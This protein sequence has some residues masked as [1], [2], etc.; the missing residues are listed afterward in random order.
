VTD[1]RFRY[2][3]TGGSL[4]VLTLINGLLTVVTLGIYSFWAKNKVRV[5]HY[6]NT[7]VA[8]ERFTYHGTGGE[9]LI[10]A[11][12]AF[13]IIFV[14]SAAAAI[15]TPLLVG[16]AGTQSLIAQAVIFVVVYLG[17]GVLFILAING[18][19]R[20]RFSRSSWRTFRFSY[21][22]KLD[23]FAV[24]MLRGLVLTVLTL[25]FYA[26]SFANQ[27]RAFLTNNARFG[28]ERFRYDGESKPLFVEYCKYVLLTIPTIGLCWIWYAAFKHRHFWNHT[29]FN[30]VR[31]QSTVT[32][33]DL[34][35]LHF[36]NA[37]LTIF[38]LGFGAPWAIV[39]MKAFYCENLSM[40]G[41]IDWVTIHQRMDQT[42]ATGEG[43]A[44]AL[45]IDVG[46]G[47]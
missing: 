9:L 26:P 2:H 18:T 40:L 41:A 19:R 7:E 28:S 22:G 27:R 12:K 15:L 25:G 1:T 47:M 34:F 45:D 11:L 14:L 20:Y 16:V 35:T 23:E 6:E 31:F 17:I 13:G 44:E 38:T 29:W 30:D 3:G 37:L 36:T 5:F 8:G 24:M 42:T 10:G 43:L 21:H 4:F 32:G 46:I 39:R 33:G